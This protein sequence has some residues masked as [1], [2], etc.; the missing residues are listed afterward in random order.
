MEERNGQG[1]VRE[2]FSSQGREKLFSDD[3]PTPTAV[4]CPQYTATDQ[5]F[6]AIDNLF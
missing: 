5:L 2:L 3:L 4:L 1:K 6:R